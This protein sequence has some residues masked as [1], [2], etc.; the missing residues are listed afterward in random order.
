MRGRPPQPTAR[1]RLT[2]GYRKHRHDQ[3][4]GEPTINAEIGDP[5]ASLCTAERRIW[6]E[7]VALADAWLRAPDRLTLETYCRLKGLERTNF[8]EMTGARLATLTKL[9]GLLGLN[10]AERTRIK[11]P[12]PPVFDP[13]DDFF[14]P[15]P[16]SRFLAPK[17]RA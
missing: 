4:A 16:S 12:E 11:V 17:G 1:L 7:V 6:R 9:G 2:G 15:L 3:R 14:D 10:P 5:P 13:A 8:S